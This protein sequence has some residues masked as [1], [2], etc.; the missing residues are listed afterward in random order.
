MYTTKLWLYQEDKD[1]HDKSMEQANIPNDGGENCLK[2]PILTLFT[3]TLKNY[4]TYFTAVFINAF[5]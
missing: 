5:K 4:A 3:V 1:T 2:S